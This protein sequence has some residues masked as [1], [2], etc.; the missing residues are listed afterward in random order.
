MDGRFSSQEHN[1]LI[2]DRFLMILLSSSNSSIK[3]T[4]LKY[5]ALFYIFLLYDWSFLHMRNLIEKL[6][7]FT[8]ILG[9][10]FSDVVSYG[11]SLMY[12]IALFANL[13]G[14][15]NSRAL[16][17]YCEA[18]AFESYIGRCILVSIFIINN[19]K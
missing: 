17:S 14:Q 15:L 12:S 5:L 11:N 1:S 8:L 10:V 18:R 13:P 16:D 9:S 4:V 19:L 7:L 6:L 3:S 2:S